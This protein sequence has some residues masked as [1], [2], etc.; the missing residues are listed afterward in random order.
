MSVSREKLYEEVWAEPITKVA[1]RYKVS[2]SYLVRVLKN[3]NIPRPYRGYWAKL[4]AGAT[5]ERP[6]LP[7]ARPGEAI[8]WARDGHVHFSTATV[9]EVNKYTPTKP[10]RTKAYRPSMHALVREAREHFKNVRD[11]SSLYLK[12]YK[13]LVVDL[14]VSKDSLERA[15]NITNQ[16]FLLLED[17]GHHVHIAPHNQY[18]HRATVDERDNTK[19]VRYYVDLWNPGRSTIVYI[20]DVPIGLTIFEIS[21]EVEVGYLNGEY[22]PIASYLKKPSNKSKS[23]F[24][25]TSTQSIP[26]GRLCIQAYSTYPGTSW[27]KQ[28][29]ESKPN[30]FSQ[31]L[32]SIVAELC[33]SVVDIAHATQTAITEAEERR[34][35]WDEQRERDRIENEEKRRVKNLKDSREELFSIIETWAEAKRIEEFF[36]DA[37][38]RAND[39]SEDD[40]QAVE[41]R[42]TEAR[43]LLGSLDALE[44]FKAW[45]TPKERE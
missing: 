7:A 18:I 38:L 30:E 22:I 34:R 11:S 36:K 23:A 4:A 28:W 21:E 33:K 26:S 37:Q 2:D 40:R 3:L 25:W 5:S 31:M 39:L 27:S 15:L 10:I 8:T 13:K 6:Q 42:L 45:K 12:P 1:K 44:R 41:N 14:L 16:F 9:I 17:L 29:R 19:P 43:R 24:A 32:K 20:Q 35:K